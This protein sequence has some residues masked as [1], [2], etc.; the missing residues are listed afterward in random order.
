[1]VPPYAVRNA[2]VTHRS[3]Y[4]GE[5]LK[6]D[7]FFYFYVPPD[8]V[9]E[10]RFGGAESGRMDV[11][12]NRRVLN[13]ENARDKAMRAL[14]E[15]ETQQRRLA[16]ELAETNRGLEKRVQERTSQL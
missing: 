10:T 1:M 9:L 6:R 14:K 15:S 16:E 11:R 13:A 4:R 5:A 2:L 8:L 7:T 12:A 3:V